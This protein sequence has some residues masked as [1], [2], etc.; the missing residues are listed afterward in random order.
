MITRN[1]LSE[2][3]IA[4][5]SIDDATLR[6]LQQ[7]AIDTRFPRT[8]LMAAMEVGDELVFPRT[9]SNNSHQLVQHARKILGNSMARWSFHNRPDGVSVLVIRR[10]DSA[11][12]EG[13]ERIGPAARFLAE[14][15]VN[16]SRLAP[17]ELF[18]NTNSALQRT[19]KNAA[20]KFLGNPHADWTSKQR[21]VGIRITRIA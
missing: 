18:K 19:R 13:L 2:I 3:I 7:L 9:R 16:E 1:L 15:E 14:L 17:R 6:I 12:Y 5:A 10:R 20:R 4:S 11:K 21:N 8:S